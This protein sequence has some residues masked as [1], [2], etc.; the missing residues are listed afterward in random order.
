MD[1][2]SALSYGRVDFFV[3]D[4]VGAS[5]KLGKT[6][7]NDRSV[8]YTLI[9]LAIPSFIEHVLET[10]MQY[11]DTAMVGHLGKEATAAV[12]CTTTISWLVGTFSWSVGMAFLALIAR[13]YGAGE[14][15]KVRRY[16]GFAFL[17]A[18][19]FGTFT[20]VISCSLSPFIPIWMK[21]EENVRY[22]ASVYFFIIRRTVLLSR[23]DD[24][25]DDT[26]NE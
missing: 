14:K 5:F 15:D 13:A 2:H 23:K 11:V 8:I 3:K 12:S 18:L 25:Y 22:D 10:L 21:S 24:V 7:A 17:T 16:T 19:I 20:A 1:N 26:E 6:K 9:I 4:N